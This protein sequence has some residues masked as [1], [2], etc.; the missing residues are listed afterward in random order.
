MSENTPSPDDIIKDPEEARAKALAV[1]DL[2]LITELEKCDGYRIYFKSRI[3][4]KVTQE[5]EKVMQEGIPQ[6]EADRA[7]IRRAAFKEILKMA[8]ED[9]IGCRSI[10]GTNSPENGI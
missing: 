7:R 3:A 10:L 9:A 4:M 8:E 5:E 2:S 1:A 6:P